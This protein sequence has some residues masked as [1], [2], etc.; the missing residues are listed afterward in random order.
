MD[1]VRHLIKFGLLTNVPIIL[2]A[3]CEEGRAA[4]AGYGARAGRGPGGHAGQTRGQPAQ[5]LQP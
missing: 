4:V 5:R 1:S 3:R 2:G